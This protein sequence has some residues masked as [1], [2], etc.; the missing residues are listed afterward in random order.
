MN[1]DPVFKSREFFF[2]SCGEEWF[3]GIFYHLFREDLKNQV[4][5]F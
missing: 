1:E 3:S 4:V 2:G 5:P